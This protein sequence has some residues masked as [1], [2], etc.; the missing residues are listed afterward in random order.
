MRFRP[1]V[2]LL[3][4]MVCVFAVAQK[5]DPCAPNLAACPDQ[6]CSQPGVLPPD[7]DLNV[8]KNRTSATGTPHRYTFAQFIKLNSKAVNKK[9]RTKWTAAEKQQVEAVE[10]DAPAVLVAYLFD[11]TESAAETCNCYLAGE[12]NHDF[13]IWLTRKNAEPAKGDKIVV[14][15]TPRVRAQIAGWDL[16]KLRTL[17]KRR[18]KVRVTGLLTFDNEHYNYPEQDIRAT[19]WEIHPVTSFEVCPPKTTCTVTGSAGWKKLETYSE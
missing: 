7:P 19:A 10:N 2:V 14:E 4:V 13:H 3:L 1:A 9:H 5:K 17:K 18:A 12:A 11:A 15:M 8:Q 16:D 6:G